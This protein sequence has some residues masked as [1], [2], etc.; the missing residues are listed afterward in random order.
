[1]KT[2]KYI[3]AKMLESSR[4]CGSGL[5]AFNMEFP[6]GRATWQRIIATARKSHNHAAYIAWLSFNC[7]SGVEGATWAARLAMQRGD[8]K[9]GWFGLHCPA[10]VEGATWAARLAVQRNDDD[11]AWLGR[12]CPDGVE[13][14]TLGARLAVQRH[15]YERDWVMAKYGQKKG[16]KL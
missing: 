2:R 12:V 16:G 6:S 9:R 10:D 4:A 1:M 8:L 15:D 3:T 13:G 14:A 5:E 11:R 7:P